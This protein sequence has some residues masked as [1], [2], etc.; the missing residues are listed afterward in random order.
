MRVLLRVVSVILVISAGMTALLI[1]RMFR[2]SSH[3]TR[4]LLSTPM[5]VITLVGWA[6]TIVAAVPSAVLLWR[7]RRAGRIGASVIFGATFVYY[8]LGLTLFRRPDSAVH[9]MFVRLVASGLF[10]VILTR[11][12]AVRACSPTATAP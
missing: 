5:G 6:I 12:S 9:A 7:Y 4:M 10:L 1:V 11:P 3:L 2:A 8:F